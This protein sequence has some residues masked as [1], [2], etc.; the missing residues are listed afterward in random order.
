MGHVVNL[1]VELSHQWFEMAQLPL[2][3]PREATHESSKTPSTTGV[4]EVV[5]AILGASLVEDALG[6]IRELLP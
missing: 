3:E 4:F 2:T 1:V 5:G 6:P